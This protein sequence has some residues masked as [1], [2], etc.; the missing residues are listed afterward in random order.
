MVTGLG[1]EPFL[2]VSISYGRACVLSLFS[3][4][5]EWLYLLKQRESEYSLSESGAHQPLKRVTSK[6]AADNPELSLMTP[7]HPVLP[8]VEDLLF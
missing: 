5:L 4:C 2:R 6:P 8:Q 3:F 7:A 1:S